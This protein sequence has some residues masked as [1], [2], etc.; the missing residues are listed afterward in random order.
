MGA[1]GAGKGTNTPYL[2]RVR[3]LTH[4]PIVMSDL[5][6]SDEVRLDP[7]SRTQTSTK[8]VSNSYSSALAFNCLLLQAKSLKANASLVSDAMVV[9]VL[10]RELPNARTA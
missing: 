10:L 2:Q 4:P 9:E 7:N 3:G 6:N 1:P 8:L 5:L